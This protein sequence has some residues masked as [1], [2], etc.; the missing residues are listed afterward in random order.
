[1]PQPILRK[2]NQTMIYLH[3]NYGIEIWGNSCKSGIKNVKESKINVLKLSV[4]RI[5]FEPSDY[6]S[7]K[8]MTFKHIHEYFLLIR[9]FK[10]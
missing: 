4:R 2:L 7:L 10:Y 8:L 9:L 5:L 3:L 6:A 1:M